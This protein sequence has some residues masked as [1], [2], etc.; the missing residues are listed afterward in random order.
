MTACHHWKKEELHG[1]G[2]RFGLSQRSQE[3]FKCHTRSLFIH[4]RGQRTVRYARDWSVMSP[5]QFYSGIILSL[6][7]GTVFFHR[8]Q[9]RNRIKLE[10]PRALFSSPATNCVYPANWNLCESHVVPLR[11]RQILDHKVF[12]FPNCNYISFCK[13]TKR[14]SSEFLKSKALPRH[15]NFISLCLINS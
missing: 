10:L 8:K 13:V 2:D 9:K 3:E 15:E 1:V 7:W 4:T 6:T 14:S 5:V 11:Y 12:P